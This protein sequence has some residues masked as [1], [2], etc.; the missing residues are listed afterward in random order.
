MLS[1]GDKAPDF[2]AVTTTGT[3]VSLH[4]Y[5]GRN[6]V[7]LY[8]YPE[9]DTGGCTA[10]ACE[11]RDSKVEYDGSNTVVFGVSTDDQAS[12][13]AF[14]A[15]YDLN[16]PLLVDTDGAICDA[17][18]VPHDPWPKRVTYLIDTDGMIARVWEQVNVRGHA[19]EVLGAVGE[20]GGA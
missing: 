19:A 16:F 2:T 1:Q 20:L 14:T 9:D 11:F 3:T 18:D 4:D 5:F 12:H 17:Y 6:N 13:Q 8:F 7:V 10:E 15:K